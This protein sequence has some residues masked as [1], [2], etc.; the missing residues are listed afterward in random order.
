MLFDRL[1][2]TLPLIG[3]AMRQ[4]HMS[5]LTLAMYLMSRTS[6]GVPEMLERGAET[7]N[8]QAFITEF[9]K[10][11]ER[12][13]QGSRMTDA[14]MTVDILPAHFIQLMSVAE[15]TGDMDETLRR[16][17]TQYAED[18]ERASRRL[19]GVLAGLIY[20]VISLFLIYN[21]FLLFRDFYLRPIQE[22]LLETG[23][24]P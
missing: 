6:I 8:N 3:G 19:S 11:S 2:L 9:R 14:L 23:V 24:F 21:I 22:A 12:V 13:R 18:A 7:T 4:I 5:R 15:E 1:S 20:L 10:A 17:S 16:L